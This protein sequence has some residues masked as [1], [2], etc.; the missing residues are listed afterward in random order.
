M[1]RTGAR[2]VFE[3]PLTLALSRRE[4]ERHRPEGEGTTPWPADGESRHKCAQ[5]CYYGWAPGVGASFYD[6]RKFD[7]GQTEGAGGAAG[8]GRRRDG[9]PGHGRRLSAAPG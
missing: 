3:V 2:A 1:G 5:V 9:R 6:N 8:G 4:R 7:A